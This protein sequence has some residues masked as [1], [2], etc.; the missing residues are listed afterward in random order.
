MENNFLLTDDL[1]WDYADGFLTAEEKIRVDAYLR[2]HPEWQERLDAIL[3]ERHAFHSL[4]LEKPRPDFS[5]RVMAAWAVETHAA[6]TATGKGKDWIIYLISAVLGLFICAA[7]VVAG[8]QAAPT[9]LP[10]ELPKISAYNYEWSAIF[11]NQ[12][13]QYGLFFVLALITL[14]F[15]EKYLEQRKMLDKLKMQG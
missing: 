7:F 10:V 13:L 2:Q 15:V 12:V 11:G 6:N 1:L 4:P 5:D 3:I 14:K 8:M 9:Q